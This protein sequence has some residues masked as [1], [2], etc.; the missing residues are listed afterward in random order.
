VI[1]SS[2]PGGGNGGGNGGELPHTGADLGPL[3][4]AGLGLLVLGGSLLLLG[5]R[6]DA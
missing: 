6:R 1:T 2:T 3:L 4:G 5:R